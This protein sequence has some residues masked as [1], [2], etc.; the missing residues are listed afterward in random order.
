MMLKDRFDGQLHKS[1]DSCYLS[2]SY[3]LPETI[4]YVMHRLS[5]LTSINFEISS[6][7]MPIIQMRKPSLEKVKSLIPSVTAR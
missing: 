4:Q 1:V 5:H 2:S 7:I 3:Y 6:T